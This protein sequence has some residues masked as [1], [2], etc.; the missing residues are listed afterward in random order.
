MGKKIGRREFLKKTAGIGATAALGAGYLSVMGKPL[1]AFPEEKIDIAVAEGDDFFNNT[2]KAVEALGG[3]E[4]FVPTGA[5]VAI[6]PNSQ[7]R[8]PGTYTKPEVVQAV[9]QMC[10]KA[11]AEEVNCLSWLE[12]KNWEASGLA[13]AV[14]EAG[15]NLILVK[16]EETFF[17]PIPVPKGE[18]LKEAWI[19]KELY[20]NDVFIDIPITKDHAGNLFTG[21][22]KNLMGINF[23]MS[24]RTFHKQDWATDKGAIEFL[25][26]CVADLNTV[27]TPTLCIVD[28]NEFITTN[29]PFGP[30]KLAKPQKV[31]AGVDRIAVDACC[32]GILG[33]NPEELFQIKSGALHGLGQIDLA[34]VSIQEIKA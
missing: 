24:N 32:A 31:V 2:V 15:A 3:M 10:K 14:E 26:Q 6:L 17:K 7:S 12:R 8:H 19:M 29:G 18:A 25:D 20:N 30:G 27:I 13:V 23:R 21:T 33:L 11:G 22:L 5:K 9:I 1:I 16:S 28:A 4:K 34:K